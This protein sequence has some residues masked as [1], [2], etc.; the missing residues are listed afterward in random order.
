MK[1][2]NSNAQDC[3]NLAAPRRDNHVHYELRPCQ[4]L[5]WT[6]L[7]VFTMSV[8]GVA[9]Q[10]V[11]STVVGGGPSGI[12]AVNAD[13][14]VVQHLTYDRHG[15]LYFTS[16]GQFRLYKIDGRGV[17]TV[18]AGNGS[19]GY[20][21]DGG[22]AV[23]AQIQ[24]WG[25]AVDDSEP[26]NVY[27]ADSFNCLVRKID[28][29]TGIITTVAGSVAYPAGGAPY[30]QCGYSG[31]GGPANQA[32]LNYV[33]GL[34][35]DPRNNDLYIAD[36][37]NGL[38]RKVA[39]G[40]ATGTITT[41]AGGGG[42]GSAAEC[43]GLPPY[44]DGASATQAFLCYPQGLALD[45]TVSPANIFITEGSW[46]ARCTIREVIGSSQNIYLVAGSY[47][48]CAYSDNV[49]ANLGLMNNPQQIQL[50]V[51]GRTSTL[52][53]ADW[54]NSSVRQFTVTYRGGIP[55][56][57]IIST[58]AGGYYGYCGD[59]GPAIYA[60]LA[61]PTGVAYDRDGNLFIGEFGNSLVREVDNDTGNI[62]TAA[63]WGYYGGTVTNYSN[64][65]GVGTVAGTDIALYQP[66]S[67]NAIAGTHEIFIGGGST[68][69]VYKFNG[70]TG[71]VRAFAGNGIPGFGGDGTPAHS[72]GTEFN[73]P[74]GE[75]VDS[76][77]NVYIGD[78]NCAI[79]EVI[80]S[81]G[82]ITTIV[83]GTAGNLNGCGE[84]GDNGP[85]TQAQINGLGVIAIDAHDNLYFT[86]FYSCDIR[87][88]VLATGVIST[89]AGNQIC[90]FNGDYGLATATQLNAP[91][92]VTLDA[93]G[94]L[95][96]ADDFNHRVRKVDAGSGYLHTIAGDAYPGYS[97]DG[98]AIY[99]SLFYLSQIAAD[100]NGNVFIADEGNGLVRWVDPGGQLVSFAGQPYS[101]GYS[102]DGG[103][104][105]AATMNSPSGI[106]QDG[107][108]NFFVSDH[109]NGVVRKI[110]AFAGYGRS[111]GQ[112][113]Y[114]PQRAGTK[115][116]NKSIVLSAIGPVTMTGITVTDGFEE[117][118]N[119][120]GERFKAGQTCLIKVRFSPRQS[121]SYAGQLTIASDAF[122]PNQ[123]NTVY[124]TGE[125]A[126]TGGMPA[127]K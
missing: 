5:L 85:A 65:I 87:K 112:L 127:R 38:V 27:L 122:L 104:A 46:G 9:Q 54:G 108:G 47:N 123:A 35:I 31:D 23:N 89:V 95:Y 22:P 12:P 26:A 103:L 37:Q 63:G 57:G 88:V 50:S 124:L 44:G 83:G 96:I 91:G 73:Y 48:F 33:S 43:G 121:G 119:C 80:A 60:C 8:S 79:R 106:T 25:V 74:V 30:P 14:S 120:V 56:P 29:S 49:P 100:A 92:A 115:S 1:T 32:Q 24:G 4:G 13:L 11:I 3:I 36:Y 41:V 20:S 82:V 98:I 78:N 69:V 18:V 75:A 7:F 105:L 102:G 113:S 81:T 6:L 17:I 72:G 45:T 42:T 62:K 39:G 21:G 118:D 64:P 52:T 99:N 101:Y 16:T 94:N 109:N 10:D 117:T 126:A 28:Q 86:E 53:F 68:P 59:G 90:G 84:S 51:K 40:T 114:D 93:A 67:V 77:G 107:D 34:A 19:W 111:T 2:E 125:G 61:N 15:N 116:A 71:K 55:E 66:R 58:I 110:T 70:K 76:K 97:G